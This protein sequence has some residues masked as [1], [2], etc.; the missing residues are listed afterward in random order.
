M[1]RQTAVVAFD[2]QVFLLKSAE[3]ALDDAVIERVLLAATTLP[4]IDEALGNAAAERMR[5]Y[6]ARD[7]AIISAQRDFFKSTEPANA[8]GCL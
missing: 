2:S 8:A 1:D 5:L 7:E 6:K 3:Q 4:R